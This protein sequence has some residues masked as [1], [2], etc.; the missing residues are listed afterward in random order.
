MADKPDASLITKSGLTAEQA[1]AFN[2]KKGQG[3]GQCHGSGYKGR[4]AIAVGASGAR[5]AAIV[6]TLLG[7]VDD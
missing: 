4:K 6:R 5:H 7:V 2:F 1:A 3:C